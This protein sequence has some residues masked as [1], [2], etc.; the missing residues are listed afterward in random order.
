MLFSSEINIRREIR[1]K[2][3]ITLITNEKHRLFLPKLARK[4]QK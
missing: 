2:I 3:F 1:K 4:T